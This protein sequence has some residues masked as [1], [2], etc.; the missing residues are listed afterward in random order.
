MEGPGGQARAHTGDPEGL[1]EV[2]HRPRPPG[3]DDRD[4]HD[5]AHGLEHRQVEAAPDAIGI[6]AVQDDLPGAQLL[7]QTGPLQGVPPRVRLPALREHAVDV[8]HPAHVHRQHHAPAAVLLGRPS[9]ELRIAQRPGVHA[10]LVGAAVQ[11]PVE[12]LQARDTPARHERDVDALRDP[13]Q[14]LDEDRPALPAGGDV[15]E[16]QLVRLVVVV[17]AGE[18]DG[19][20]HVA[21]P[22]EAHALDDPSVLDVETGNDAFYGHDLSSSS[23]SA[24]RISASSA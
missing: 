14:E 2:L 10:H 11:D 12:V 6:D 18:D 21:Q 13:A 3:G 7:P 16:H 4:A 19:V 23:E 15:V 8:P 5:P 1:G 17:K 24:D 20:L 9:E 22:L